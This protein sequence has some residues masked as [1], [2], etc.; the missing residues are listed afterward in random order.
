MVRSN[1]IKATVPVRDLLC[2]AEEHNNYEHD[3]GETANCAG[4]DDGDEQINR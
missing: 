3:T 1:L 2:K 4:G